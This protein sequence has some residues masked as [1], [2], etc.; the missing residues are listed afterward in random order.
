MFPLFEEIR[1]RVV[2]A[3]P[4]AGYTDRVF[5]RFAR[6]FGAD[7]VFTEM[8]SAEG[9]V[10]STKMTLKYMEYS[11]EEMPIGV[12]FFTANPDY[13]RR[14]ARMVRDM[15]FAVL[16]I[17][18]GCPVRKV[19]K[20]G[21]G[22]ALLTTPEVAVEVVDAA[23][24]SGL[25]VSVKIRCGFRSCEEWHQIKEFLL[26]PL[27][28]LNIAFLTVHPRSATQLYSGEA[29]WSI[30]KDAVETLDIP[31]L[32][33]GDLLNLEMVR[34]RVE[35]ASPRGVM[36]AR[37]AVG[38]FEIFA[39][40][41]ALFEGEKPPEFSI[42]QRAETMLQFIR[43]EAQYRG[44]IYAVKWGRKFLVRFFKNFPG[45][46]HYRRCLQQLNTIEDVEQ[47]LARLIRELS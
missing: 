15:G 42:A 2:V 30:V 18:M 9:L 4:M 46:V 6:R 8:V 38:N 24:E 20:K 37:G 25:P 47:I 21:A 31:V 14:A 29:N 45:A 35:Y 11:P 7:L 19:V 39:Q 16:D 17:N 41:N 27:Q 5:R 36:I 34:E 26:I 1:R 33:S 23:R 40:V 13:M 3:A 32:G 44:E 12:Q 43:E 28:R 10:H 22:A